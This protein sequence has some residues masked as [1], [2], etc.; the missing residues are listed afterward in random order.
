MRARHAAGERRHA[1]QRHQ[2]VLRQRMDEQRRTGRE[3]AV[4]QDLRVHLLHQL[5]VHQHAAF[6]R[7]VGARYRDG[8]R[9]AT[10]ADE[11]GVVVRGQA[12]VRGVTRRL[13]RT[14]PEQRAG[15][16]AGDL[17]PLHADP[18]RGNRPP[19]VHGTD[20]PRQLPHRFR[21]DPGAVGEAHEVQ[22]RRAECASQQLEVVRGLHGADRLEPHAL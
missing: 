3:L 9:R 4:Q 5:I 12:R 15:D 22:L 21:R 13:R 14:P 6:G 20:R 8:E 18:L 2:A 11:H 17:A 1:L 19:V 16:F 10:Q 7:G